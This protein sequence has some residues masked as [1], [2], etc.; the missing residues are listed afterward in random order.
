[1]LN[2]NPVLIYRK[3]EI[4]DL[5]AMIDLILE[6]DIAEIRDNKSLLENYINAFHKINSDP[7]QYL[8]V[9][10]IESKVVAMCQLTIIPYLTF[11]GSLRMQI[12]TVRVAKKYRSKKIGFQMME[13]AISYAQKKGVK[14]VQLTTNKKR[15]RAKNFYEKLGFEASHEGMKLNLK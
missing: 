11:G 5:D 4:T 9:V 6:N 2:N 15:D 14:I 12:E 7:N 13:E 10:E 8:M 1:M 3:A